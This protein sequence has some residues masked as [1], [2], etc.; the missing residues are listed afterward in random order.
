MYLRIRTKCWEDRIASAWNL[1]YI[2]EHGRRTSSVVYFICN[3]LWWVPKMLAQLFMCA[4]RAKQALPLYLL[5]GRSYTRLRDVLGSVRRSDSAWT[6]LQCVTVLYSLTCIYSLLYT[7]TLSQRHMV[8]H[9]S[10]KKKWRFGLNTLSTRIVFWIYYL[11]LKM[12][13]QLIAGP[14][15]LEQIYVWRGIL[16]QRN[17]WLTPNNSEWP[18]NI[19]HAEPETI[20]LPEPCLQKLKPRF[21]SISKRMYSNGFS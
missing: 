14:K 20:L 17:I 18:W 19:F 15:V 5:S 3:C 9:P 2:W 21:S 16:E 4:K 10:F 1:F 6:I 13:W 12:K 8:Q 11:L 7:V